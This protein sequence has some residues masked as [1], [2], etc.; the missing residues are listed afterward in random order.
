MV[1]AT[2][3]LRFLFM[4]YRVTRTNRLKARSLVYFKVGLEVHGTRVV[5]KKEIKKDLVLVE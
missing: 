4:L 2:F 1:K 3:V 5:A